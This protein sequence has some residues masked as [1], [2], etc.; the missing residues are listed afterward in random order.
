MIP[1]LPRIAPSLVKLSYV[2]K[3]P[4]MKVELHHRSVDK[5][6]PEFEKNL[7]SKKF[8]EAAKEHKLSDS[9]LRRYVENYGGYLASKDVI[10]VI[11]SRTSKRNYRVKRLKSGRL[12]CNCK[13]WQYYHSVR[14]SDCDHIDEIRQG[15]KKES[16]NPFS[17]IARG[18]AASRMVNKAQK[19][20]VHGSVAQENQ[21]R[22][23]AGQP[24]VAAPQF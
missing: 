24:L 5:D 1:N 4:K 16:Q 17:M 8:Q 20:L 3:S 9:K 13:D 12:G 2:A 15:L 10:G 7:K 21:R 23:Y 22:L 18:V 19:E 14:D 6:W 11:P